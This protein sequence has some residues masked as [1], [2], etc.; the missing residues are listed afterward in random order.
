MMTDEQKMHYK[1]FIESTEA[2]E[3]YSGKR[4][5]LYGIDILRKIC[6][7]P[8]LLRRKQKYEVNNTFILSY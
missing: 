2:N 7:H 1:S 5:V 3:I 4:N 8:D 6:N